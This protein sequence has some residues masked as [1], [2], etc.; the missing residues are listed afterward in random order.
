[1]LSYAWGYF[2]FEKNIKLDFDSFDNELDF[3]SVLFESFLSRYV[4]NGLH[5]NYLVQ[6]DDLA[7]IR[8]KINFS[9][10]V[11]LSLNRTN[12]LNC[13]YDEFETD[14][15]QNR[16]I[17]ATGLLILKTTAR[18]DV[19][20][21]IKKSLLFF[22]KVK[23]LNWKDA[24]RIKNFQIQRGDYR[25]RFLI[26][27]C[28]YII[29][30][31]S[32]S[33]KSGKYELSSFTRNEKQMPYIFENFIRNFYKKK[34]LNCIVGSTHISWD[35]DTIDPYLPIMRT[36]TSIID[37]NRSEFCIIDTKYTAEVLQYNWNTPKFKSS[38]LYQL[39]SYVNNTKKTY[40]MVSGVL[41]YP[42]VGYQIDI[43]QEIKGDKYRIK[44]ISLNQ[45]WKG[46]EV[47]LLTLNDFVRSKVLL[48]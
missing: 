42:T 27:V 44:T 31:S 18:N 48:A 2:N 1:M 25:L 11:R 37:Q 35:A 40:D 39:F 38:H 7:L 21:S 15:K 28:R 16:L 26:Q 13:D 33:E 20:V 41:L 43:E 24:K 4:K 29:D 3:F 23:S 22:G 46:I 45:D 6:N 14:T 19:K 30:N 8:G 10:S 32:F 36:D 9:N 5:R 12:K 17:K 34:L 47:D